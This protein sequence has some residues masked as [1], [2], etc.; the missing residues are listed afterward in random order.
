MIDR[1]D[2]LA[3]RVLGGVAFAGVLVLMLGMAVLMV[4]I[5]TR[6]SIGFSILGIIDINQLA[7]MG[8]V[9]LVLPLAF[10]REAHITVD[11]VT[12]R[13]PAR[14]LAGVEALS[15]LVALVLL[16]AILWCSAGQAGFALR[17]G[18]K[19]DT[20]GLPMIL[21]WAPLLAGFA[22]SI[23]SVLIVGAR[24]LRGVATGDRRRPVL[25]P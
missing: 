8:C 7:Q 10:L 17:Q 24:A 20:L 12:D 16:V 2:R 25:P 14:A 21:Y 18:D 11:F 1:L 5:V 6:K 15:A 13:L 22:L 23:F 19:S 4:D 3:D 9:F